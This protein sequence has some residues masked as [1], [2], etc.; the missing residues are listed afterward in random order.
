MA[1]IEEKP[2]PVDVRERVTADIGD[3]LELREDGLIRKRGAKTAVATRADVPERRDLP[4]VPAKEGERVAYPRLVRVVPSGMPDCTVVEGRLVPAD[5]KT[6]EPLSQ[7]AEPD[8]R[9]APDVRIR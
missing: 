6:G 7:G 9:E 3:E 5:S 4:P 1:Q 8:E 2:K